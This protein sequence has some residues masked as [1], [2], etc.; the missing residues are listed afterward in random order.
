MTITDTALRDQNIKRT[1]SYLLLVSTSVLSPNSVPPQ[2]E[3]F[4]SYRQGQHTANSFGTLE[5]QETFVSDANVLEALVLLHENL[6]L[7]QVVLDGD[8]SRLL[9]TN[10]ENLYA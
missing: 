4:V 3:D 6:L 1:F 5:V 7:S 10:M 2:V 8:L 9:Y